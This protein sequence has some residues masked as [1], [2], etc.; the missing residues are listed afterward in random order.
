MRGKKA[1]ALRR[2]AGVRVKPP[3][4]GTP[5]LERTWYTRLR[6]GVPTGL[7]SNRDATRRMR[8]LTDGPVRSEHDT[9]RSQED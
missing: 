2:E 6:D 3:K 7:R 1:K 4:E 9:R 8:R 5:L